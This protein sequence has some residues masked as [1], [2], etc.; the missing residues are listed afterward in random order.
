[1]LEKEPPNIEEL[2]YVYVVNDDIV[3][4]NGELR[5]SLEP[6]MDFFKN[7][8]FVGFTETEEEFRER[9]LAI[10]RLVLM[11]ALSQIFF[12]FPLNSNERSMHPGGMAAWRHLAREGKARRYR[13]DMRRPRDVRM[14]KP[15]K[16]R[17]R[18]VF[19]E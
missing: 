16:Y 4:G 12:G 19:V 10:R 5:Y 14:G 6:E 9:G 7:K 8:P 17:M 13:Q 3:V 11:N 2:V 15:P 1:S 18:Y